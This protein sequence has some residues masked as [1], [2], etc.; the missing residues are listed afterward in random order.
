V[1]LLAA[2]SMLSLDDELSLSRVLICTAVFSLGLIVG[3]G[4][5][6]CVVP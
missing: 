2:M 1:R 5:A 3:A 4:I 6:V